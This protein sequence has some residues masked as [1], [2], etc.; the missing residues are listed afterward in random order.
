MKKSN[1]DKKKEAIAKKTDNYDE[2]NGGFI[3]KTL[4]SEND[5]K[6]DL[7]GS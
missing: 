2:E 5:D 1:K 6:I 7:L 4:K 3:E